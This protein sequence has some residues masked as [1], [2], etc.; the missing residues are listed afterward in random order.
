MAW[1]WPSL[2]KLRSPDNPPGGT[3]TLLA[4]LSWW[5]TV[6]GSLGIGG[7]PK[8]L[9]P[10]K[11]GE[12]KWLDPSW[13]M[14]ETFESQHIS[15]WKKSP[16]RTAASGWCDVWYH[17]PPVTEIHP[18]TW[19][20]HVTPKWPSKTLIGR[21][22]AHPPIRRRNSPPRTHSKNWPSFLVCQPPPI[23]VPVWTHLLLFPSSPR[24][25]DNS[26]WPEAGNTPGDDYTPGWYYPLLELTPTRRRRRKTLGQRP[27]SQPSHTLPSSSPTFFDKKNDNWLY[28]ITVS[29]L[30]HL[31]LV[32]KITPPSCC[33]QYNTMETLLDWSAT[34]QNKIFF[35]DPSIFQSY[36]GDGIKKL[37]KLWKLLR[38]FDL[39]KR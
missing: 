4:P 18:L 25:M 2:S 34:R 36:H 3:S 15:G 31:I 21:R 8:Y 23:T 20:T 11:V 32:L 35:K 38:L 30:Q 26:T 28:T 39:P 5:I 9:P 19:C 22:N 37:H 27:K 16:G 17:N 7:P 6:G 13:T 12:R 10:V 14:M 33:P 29:N 1:I 24:H